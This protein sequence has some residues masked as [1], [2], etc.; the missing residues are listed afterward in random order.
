MGL[1]TTESLESLERAM[2]DGEQ[3]I[4]DIDYTNAEDNDQY[5]VN[6]NALSFNIECRGIVMGIIIAF[7][8]LITFGLFFGS[9]INGYAKV[10]DAILAIN[11]FEQL[12]DTA[13]KFI[14]EKIILSFFS[15]VCFHIMTLIY[16][17]QLDKKIEKME[18]NIVNAILETHTLG[19]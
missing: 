17:R 10:N 12:Q 4:Q 13:N 14:I 11:K 9:I 1:H 3:Y 16:Q 18:K 8:S 2:N 7:V 19:I 15:C 6:P 5:Y